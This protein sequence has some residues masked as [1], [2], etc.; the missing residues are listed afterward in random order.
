M[1]ILKVCLVGKESQKNLASA[2]QVIS[3]KACAQKE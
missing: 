1:I 2:I 3:L